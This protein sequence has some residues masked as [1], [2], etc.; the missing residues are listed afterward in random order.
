MNGG[1]DVLMLLGDLGMETE[2]FE[3][4]MTDYEQA[5]GLL[6]RH[7]QVRMQTDQLC[8]CLTSASGPFI[9]CPKI[10]G[11]TSRLVLCLPESPL[12]GVTGHESTLCS[13]LCGT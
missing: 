5:L 2:R 6:K 9:Q 3:S 10:F 13:T 1:A 11:L 4:A 8:H 7:L 12:L